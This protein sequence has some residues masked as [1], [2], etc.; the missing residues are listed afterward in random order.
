MQQPYAP[1]QDPATS[2]ALEQ[3]ADMTQAGIEPVWFVVG[4]AV[5]IAFG[6]LVIVAV[7]LDQWIRQSNA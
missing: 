1:Y 2:G 4:G 7:A 5:A 3:A 6:I